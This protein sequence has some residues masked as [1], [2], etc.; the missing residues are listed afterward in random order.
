[1]AEGVTSSGDPVSATRQFKTSSAFHAIVELENAPS[2]S[3]IKAV[4][5]ALDTGGAEPCNTRLIE[6]EVTTSGTRNVWFKYTPP[7]KF[8]VGLYKVDISVNGN[9]NND[10]DFTVK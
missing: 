3:K 8:P 4:W 6:T 10:V 2:N 9:L 1:M 7:E 5:Y